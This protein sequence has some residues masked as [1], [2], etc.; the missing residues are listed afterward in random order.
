MPLN[1]TVSRRLPVPPASGAVLPANRRTCCL[2]DAGANDPHPAAQ[3][4]QL[5][6]RSHLLGA[7][8]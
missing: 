1:G 6:L 4:S 3:G 7:A 2:I 5:G 8:R